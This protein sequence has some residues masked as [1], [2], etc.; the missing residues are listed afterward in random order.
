MHFTSLCN[1]PDFSH[2]LKDGTGHLA[3]NS[4]TFGAGLSRRGR[5]FESEAALYLCQ[6]RFGRAMNLAHGAGMTQINL[7][8]FE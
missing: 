1:P 3:L 8:S 5:G 6:Q 2:F 4:L 7:S